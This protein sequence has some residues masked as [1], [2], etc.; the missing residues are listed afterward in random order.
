MDTNEYEKIVKNTAIYPIDFSWDAL[1][2]LFK[3]FEY[4]SAVVEQLKK[5]GRDGDYTITHSMLS[6]LETARYY[7]KEFVE[8]A[9][10]HD[11]AS[12]QLRDGEERDAFIYPMLGLIGEVGE[13]VKSI[14]G[15]RSNFDVT[16]E[17][18]DVLWYLTEL[19]R[20]RGITLDK[21][22][23]ENAKKVTARMQQ[24]TVH[25]DGSD[26]E[27][28]AED[29]GKKE[30][31]K[32]QFN[33]KEM[34]EFHEAWQKFCDAGFLQYINAQ[35]HLFGYAITRVVDDS[36]KNIMVQPMKTKFRGF[37]VE[38]NDDMYTKLTCYMKDNVDKLYDTV[39]PCAP[40]SVAVDTA[41]AG[42]DD[43]NITDLIFE[44]ED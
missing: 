36:G 33:I 16:R 22:M 3:G 14:I 18:G 43:V 40:E 8:I 31:A 27:L 23:D 13:L 20:L 30:L 32:T 34:E 15:N 26:R 35:L 28:N 1:C 4:F 10:P 41:A 19:M 11:G 17:A 2:D 38:D 9:M 25:G 24:G 7:I 44:N 42:A 29:P 37:S 6:E 5:A 39:K 21:V 12:I